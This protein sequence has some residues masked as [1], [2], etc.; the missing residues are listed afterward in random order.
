MEKR[1]WIAQH[2]P[3]LFTNVSVIVSVQGTMAARF[4]CE[5]N[6]EGL[7]FSHRQKGKD[8]NAPYKRIQKDWLF[9][10]P[11]RSSVGPNGKYPNHSADTI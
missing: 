11:T 8:F 3:D 5:N 6:K 2:V 1:Y 4:L 9:H 7:F 10:N